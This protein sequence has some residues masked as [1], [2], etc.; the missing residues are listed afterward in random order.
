[1]ASELP[2][3]LD[4]GAED[5]AVAVD[6]EAE[7]DTE[8]NIDAL[9]AGVAVTDAE[10]PTPRGPRR[11]AVR[12]PRRPLGV[13]L[14]HWGTLLVSVAIIAVF[15]VFQLEPGCPVVSRAAAG[16][17]VM[18]FWWVAQPLP[19]HIV[20]M[21]PV[22]VFPLMGVARASAVCA[23]YF[24]YTTFVTIGGHL[25][26][27]AIQRWNLHR[28]LALLVLRL[29]G[30]KPTSILA[31]F[32]LSSW[33]LS[34]W[35][36]N[37]ASCLTMLPVALVVTRVLEDT[38]GPEARCLG[39]VMLMGLAYSA[40]IGGMATP[41]GTPANLVLLQVVDLRF[42]DAPDIGFGRWM[43]FAVPLSFVLLLFVFLFFSV[44][45]RWRLSRSPLTGVDSRDFVKTELHALGPFGYEEKVVTVTFVLLAG[46]WIT[47][48][49]IGVVPGWSALLPPATRRCVDDSTVAMALTLPL[50]LLPRRGPRG[51][52]YRAILEWSEVAADFNF[53]VLLMLGGGF[54][55]AKAFVDSG[56]SLYV[57]LRL[58]GLAHAP[59]P[60]VIVLL[61]AVPSLV[62]EFSSNVATTQ[63]LLPIAAE[64]G[65]TMGVNPLILMVPVC[66]ACQCSF[67][68]PMAT[69]P[70]MVMYSTGLVPLRLMAYYGAVVDVIAVG[71][72]SLFMLFLFPLLSGFPS[73]IPDWARTTSH[74]PNSTFV[75]P[76]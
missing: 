63:L 45:I 12:T 8:A 38:R 71:W 23:A 55:I 43:G 15:E 33:F 37:T 10:G 34:M 59:L 11:C 39:P 64:L 35:M 4:K 42:P 49:G 21:T 73:G 29:F 66:I 7:P 62:T 75:C 13:P 30:T 32:M 58:R 6:G 53:E 51:A 22:A 40:T 26:G 36:S 28:R 18:A 1:M 31:A 47:R 65:V 46:L 48:S 17:V 70:N 14:R 76:S 54:A 41:I 9:P 19:P 74:S 3:L 57:G 24:N 56:L 67:I 27:I 69:P 44:G 5:S 68:L 50:F 61:T 60:L 16:I 20:A 2:P 52:P 25:L 72:V